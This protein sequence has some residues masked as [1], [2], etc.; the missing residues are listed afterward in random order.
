MH[1]L[2]S[3]HPCNSAVAEEQTSIHAVVSVFYG[4]IFRLAIPRYRVAGQSDAL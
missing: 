2:S 3:L 4:E 1:F